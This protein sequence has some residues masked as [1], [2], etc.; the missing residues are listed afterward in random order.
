[1]PLLRA[2]ASQSADPAW[3]V[4]EMCWSTCA[5]QHR[6]KKT[7]QLLRYT[8]QPC[9]SECVCVCVC[10][11]VLIDSKCQKVTRTE[12]SLVASQW[13]VETLRSPCT[14]KGVA[15][16][17]REKRSP[18]QF[19]TPHS[20]SIVKLCR[21]PGWDCAHSDLLADTHLRHVCDHNESWTIFLPQKG[22]STSK[23]CVCAFLPNTF[24]DRVLLCLILRLVHLQARSLDLNT[25]LHP[26]ETAQRRT[27]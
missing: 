2:A 27:L 16:T 14:T 4:R 19:Q 5:T 10:C 1:M 17:R 3:S 22:S 25:S 11:R 18:A 7:T 6:T 13:P 23:C 24:S 21:K 9:C 26:T 20:R 12:L 15:C 8:S